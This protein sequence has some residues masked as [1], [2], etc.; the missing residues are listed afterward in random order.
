MEQSPRAGVSKAVVS[1]YRNSVS[2][3]VEG[4]DEGIVNVL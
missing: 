3:N 4:R 1:L 2:R